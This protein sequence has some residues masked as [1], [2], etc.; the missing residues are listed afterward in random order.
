MVS[1][2]LSSLNSAAAIAIVFGLCLMFHEAGHFAVAKAFGMKV[3]E[4]AMGFGPSIFRFRRGETLYRFNIFFFIGAYVKIAGME[5]GAENVERGFHSKPRWQGALVILAGSMCNILLAVII[6]TAVT[7]W[8]GLPDPNDNSVY[9]AKVSATAPAYKAGLQPGDKI[10]AVDRERHSL[11]IDTVKPGSLAAKAGITGSL[12]LSK[13]GAVE[14]YTPAELV[15]ALSEAKPPKVALEAINYDARDL[16]EQFKTVMLP[17]TPALKAALADAPAEAPMAETVLEKTLGLKF[18]PLH[19]GS[20][21]G[22]INL[23]PAQT[24]TLTV[25]REGQL[26]D[27]PVQTIKVNGRKAWRDETGMIRS[28]IVPIGRIGIVM[29]GASRPAGIGESIKI[30]ALSTYGS[31]ATVVLSIKAMINKQ[32]AAEL[33]GPVAIMA[34]SAERARVGWDAVLTWCGVISSILAIM[35]LFPFPP[36]DGF[37]AVLIGLEGIMQRRVPAKLEFVVSLAGFFIVVLLGVVLIFKD[38]ANLVMHG[39]P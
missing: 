38:T 5:P 33:A 39:T 24:V 22:Y 19:Q 14:V 15:Q 8:T 30:G 20:L 28:S 23:R 29:R 31:A 26:L 25:S 4:F 17:L 34:I 2:L 13:V 35:N 9:V 6:F 36:F 3:E 16:G 32:V 12:E 7:M 11:K 18:E 1:M 27:L 21:V 10:V 37:K